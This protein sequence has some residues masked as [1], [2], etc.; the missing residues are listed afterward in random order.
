M[1]KFERFMLGHSKFPNLVYTKSERRKAWVMCLLS[2]LSFAMMVY[3]NETTGT[4]FMFTKKSVML[5]GIAGMVFG[6]SAWH[7]IMI[8]A[9][10]RQYKDV[11]Q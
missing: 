1:N 9:I 8:S 5:F 10:A 6:L 11:L 7:N 4:I 2:M 3:G